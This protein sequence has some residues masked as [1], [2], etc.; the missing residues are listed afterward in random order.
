MTR[1]P[2][3]IAAPLSLL[4]V[5]LCLLQSGLGDSSDSS[6][7]SDGHVPFSYNEIANFLKITT[8]PMVRME[9]F[10]LSNS[11]PFCDNSTVP[12]NTLDEIEPECNRWEV[13]HISNIT[14]ESSSS[15]TGKLT[16][17]HIFNLSMRRSAGTR[18]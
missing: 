16:L 11:T 5:L 18:T 6:T 13:R 7:P 1:K 2:G 10:D 17:F 14:V 9:V 4:V 8:R 12:E 3:V 15:F